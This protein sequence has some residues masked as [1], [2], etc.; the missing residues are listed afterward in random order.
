MTPSTPD[1][2][3]FRLAKAG[4]RVLP[5]RS[6]KSPDGVADRLRVAGF[7][8][9]Q[10]REAFLWAAESFQD[11]S[12]A[13]QTAWRTLAKEEDKHLGW[14]LQRL[15]ALGFQVE[16]RPVSDALWRSFIQCTTAEAF[17]VYMAKAEERGRIAGERFYEALNKIDPIS[18]EIFRKIAEEEVQHIQLA[19]RYFPEKFEAALLPRTSESTCSTI[20]NI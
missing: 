11:T 15:K 9:I 13:L 16:D 10:A 19:E 3:P 4:E 6:L 12:H 1:W 5:P 7:A 20:R 18:A 8:E 14:L 2:Q 17:A